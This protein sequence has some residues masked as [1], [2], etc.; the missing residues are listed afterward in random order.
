MADSFFDHGYDEESTDQPREI[1]DLKGNDT[2]WENRPS[3]DR[4]MAAIMAY[5]PFLCFIPLIKMRNDS[6]AYFHAR[7]GLVLFFIEVIAFIFSFPHLS[8]LFWIAILIGCIGAAIAGVMFAVQGK[9]YKLPI[10]GQLA[11]KLKM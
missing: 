8:Q 2:D 4:R 5:I 10:V 7:Q 6:Y 1:P 9:T 3:E 11:D